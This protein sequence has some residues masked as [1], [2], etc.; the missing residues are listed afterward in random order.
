[1]AGA[2]YLDIHDSG[3]GIHFTVRHVQAAS[4]HQLSTEFIRHARRM[5]QAGTCI[6]RHVSSSCCSTL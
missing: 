2:T 6:N 5:T 1:L 4:E 3:G